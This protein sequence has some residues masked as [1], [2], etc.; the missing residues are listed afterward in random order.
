M[1]KAKRRKENVEKGELLEELDES[2][3]DGNKL[4]A[5]TMRP[6]ADTMRPLADKM[7]PSRGRCTRRSGGRRKW[8]R[9]S[10]S[11]SLTSR[12]RTSA[13]S[14]LP[15]NHL[16]N[17][18]TNQPINQPSNQPLNQSTNQPFNH[19]TNQ[20]IKQSN[21]QTINRSTNQP[22]NQSVAGGQDAP[23]AEDDQ[24]EGHRRRLRAFPLVMS[25]TTY[26]RAPRS[27]AVSLISLNTDEIIPREIGSPLGLIKPE[28]AQ[29]PKST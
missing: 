6:L 9:T 15:T 13:R 19:S 26:G 18:S 27:K 29:Y 7:R 5:Y 1:Y 24:G 28:R 14:H 17:Q 3:A 20:T 11:R 10:C 12:L 4:L 16:I 23:H 21:N 22:I 2:F 8:R 25:L